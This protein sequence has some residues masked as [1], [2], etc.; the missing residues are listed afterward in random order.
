MTAAHTLIIV[1]A[2]VA[3]NLPF[4]TRRIFFVGPAPV[5]PADKSLVWRCLE[6]IVLYF[7]VGGIAAYFETRSYGGLYNQDWQFYAITACLFLVFAYP[8]FAV[9]Y[10]WHKRRG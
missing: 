4:A 3:A 1:L 9:R 2:L 7:V 8:G 10:L 5:A 6:L